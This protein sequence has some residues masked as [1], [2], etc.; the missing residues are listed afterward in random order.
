MNRARR[1]NGYHTPSAGCCYTLHHELSCWSRPLSGHRFRGAF[2]D[3]N[4]WNQP[5][6]INCCIQLQFLSFPTFLISITLRNSIPSM[7]TL[8][9]RPGCH[10]IRIDPDHEMV[11]VAHDGTG[12]QTNSEY[13]AQQPDAVDDRQGKTAWSNV[14]YSGRIG[15]PGLSGF[16]SWVLAE[17]SVYLTFT[18]PLY[19]SAPYRKSIM[20]YITNDTNKT[21]PGHPRR[22]YSRWLDRHHTGRPAARIGRCSDS[23][24]CYRWRLDD[25]WV[26]AYRESGTNLHGSKWQLAMSYVGQGLDVD[27]RAF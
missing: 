22:S 15:C 18:R 12:T 25:I 16:S 6:G 2:N 21:K 23:T 19:P 3:V 14:G 7:C 1:Q 17:Y 20:S 5:R 10:L 13:A 11:M 24:A 27:V 4:S 9:I 8:F 26:L